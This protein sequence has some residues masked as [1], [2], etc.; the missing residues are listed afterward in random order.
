MS[1][2]LPEEAWIR[3]GKGALPWWSSSR[4]CAPDAVGLGVIPG[5]RAG[6]HILQLRPSAAKQINKAKYLLKEE[7]RDS[8]D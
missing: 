3:G 7:E 2:D 5:Q 6:S 4:D 1:L 8:N